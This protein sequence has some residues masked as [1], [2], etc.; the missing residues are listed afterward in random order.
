MSGK[1]LKSKRSLVLTSALIVLANL[2]FFSGQTLAQ[3]SGATLTG[4][5]KDPSGAFIPKAR[6]LITNVATG[7]TRS[8]D[9]D[10]AGLYSAPNLAPGGYEVKVSAPGFATLNR[11][12]I[13]LTVGA[14]Q[15]LDFTMQVGQATQSVEVVGEAPMVDVVSSTIQA[16]VNSTTVR[17]LPLN[18][19]SWTDLGS[20]QPGVSQPNTQMPFT[21]SGR[22]QRGFGT[23][24]AIS[25]NRPDQNNYRLD[26]LNVNDYA[27]G[28]PSNVIGGAL[29]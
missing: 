7:V 17:E 27:N 24:V 13:T 1:I 19:R 28:A 14:Q 25:G 29:G 9:T 22:G 16:Q 4:T 18:G 21:A 12:G 6:V 15:A 10:T 23:Q 5:V 11:K 3:V 8:L 20:L 26:G 2:L